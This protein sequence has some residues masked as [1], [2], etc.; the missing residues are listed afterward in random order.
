MT[1]KAIKHVALAFLLAVETA[2]AAPIVYSEAVSGDLDFQS[3]G[4]LDAGVNTV[5]GRFCLGTDC[6]TDALDGF[7][8]TLPTGLALDESRF[9]FTSAPIL[10][11]SASTVFQL[12]AGSA[13][14][15]SSGTIGLMTGASLSLFDAALPL[16]TMG[17]YTLFH[18]LANWGGTQGGS[19]NVDY[20]WT[21]NV[22]GAQTPGGQVPV[23]GTLALFGIGLAGLAFRRRSLTS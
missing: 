4:T 3:V 2:V 5:Q 1:T 23:P 14:L 11:S 10:T 22:S 17:E 8:F 12:R 21:L 6:L 18:A 9:T 20:T 19:L 15:A 7:L 16:T 13:I